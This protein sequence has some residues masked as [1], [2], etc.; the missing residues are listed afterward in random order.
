VRTY[1]DLV[2][3]LRERQGNTEVTYL[4]FQGKNLVV[5]APSAQSAPHVP[6]AAEP[7]VARR[8]IEQA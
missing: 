7:E 1:E 4:G 6:L 8:E 5:F 2:G 3:W